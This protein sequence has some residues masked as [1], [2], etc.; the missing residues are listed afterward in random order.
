MTHIVKEWQI[1]EARLN[2]SMTP[3]LFATEEVYKI[4]A[5]WKPFRDAYEEAKKKL[6]S[7][8]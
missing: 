4:V 7:P 6:F 3:D 8:K 2:T 5:Q 1:N